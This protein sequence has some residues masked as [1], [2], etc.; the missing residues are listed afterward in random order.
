MPVAVL[1]PMTNAKA[2]GGAVPAAL[3]L[4]AERGFSSLTLKDVADASGIGVDALRSRYDDVGDILQEAFRSGQ[5]AMEADLRKIRK[6]GLEA[7][8]SALH[9]GLLKGI[10]PWGPE[11]YLGM[12]SQAMSDAVLRDAVR[13]SSEKINFAVKA[14]LA[15]M[16]ALSIIEAVENVEAV[17]RELVASFME[18][19]APLAQGVPAKDVRKEWSVRASAMLTPSRMTAPSAPGGS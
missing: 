17:N 6:G 19:L 12:L 10:G 9:S 8:M 18:S 14:Y 7:H 4:I 5:K 15:Q 3:R 11:L 13:R 16:V 2:D 1:R